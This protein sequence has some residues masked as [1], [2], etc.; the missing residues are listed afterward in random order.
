MR[1]IYWDDLTQNVK[2]IDQRRLPTSLEWIT[3]ANAKDVAE[4]IRTMAIRGAPAIGAAGAYGLALTA[5]KSNAKSIEDLEAEINISI[6]VLKAS[7]PTAINLNWALDRML[8]VIQLHLF[9]IKEIVN[10]LI[11]E[12]KNIAEEDIQTN[13]RIAEF[14]SGSIQDGDVIIH[15]CNTGSLATV[16]G[17]TALGVIQEGWK[18][19][20]KIHVLVDETRPRLQGARLTSWELQQT[21]IPYEIITDNAAGYFLQKHIATKVIFGADR[22]SLNGDVA[23]KVGTYMLSLAA[24]ENE[25]P[26]LTVFP[27]SSFDSACTDG[28]SI[29]I[30]MRDESEVLE[31][32]V[33]G[34]KTVPQGAHALNPA[35]DITPH[36]LITA[37]ITDRGIL[38]PPF[39]PQSIDLMGMNRGE[40]P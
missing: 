27:S 14:G 17:G 33:D 28:N 26:V 22:V 34:E 7:R 15:H 12:A 20:K 32:I 21:G 38:Y 40:K 10:S 13:K 1:T 8:K 39:N 25:I 4:A 30:E 3:C 6:Q 29:E 19:G 9:S 23:N 11:Q 31:L 36:H 37:W 2:M 18:Q 24:R 16:E 5:S 35:F